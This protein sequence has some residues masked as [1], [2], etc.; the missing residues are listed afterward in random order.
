MPHTPIDYTTLSS[1]TQN[2]AT[3]PLLD[4]VQSNLQEPTPTSTD[5]NTHSPQPIIEEP[6]PNNT[7]DNQPGPLY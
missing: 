7:H 2:L 6:V 3:H 1:P 5:I 4:L